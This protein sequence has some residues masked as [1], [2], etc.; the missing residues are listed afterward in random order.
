MAFILSASDAELKGALCNAI[1]GKNGPVAVV[2]LDSGACAVGPSDGQV[3][4]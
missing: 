3:F 2:L 4:F 1:D